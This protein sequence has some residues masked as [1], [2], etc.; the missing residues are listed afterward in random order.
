VRFFRRQASGHGVFDDDV[1]LHGQYQYSGA[2]APLSARL[3][4]ARQSEILLQAVGEGHR[5]ILDVGC[6]DGYFTSVL[7]PAAQEVVGIDPS[8]SAIRAARDQPDRPTNVLFSFETL[9]DYAKSDR[10]FDV[11][12]LRGVIHHAQ[13]PTA[14][15]RDISLI[16]DRVI[17]L[18]P[19]GL[20]PALKAV[21]RLSA[22]HRAH[23]ERSFTPRRLR[24][25][26]ADAGFRVDWEGIGVVV[27]YFAPDVL[28]R[29]LSRAEPLVEATPGLRQ[30][31]CGTRV[32]S[33]RT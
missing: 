24:R 25:W 2:S 4:T 12:V 18:E 14:L 13:D 15:L 28:A 16:T 7:S 26:M 9:H 29:F 19:N 8:H 30:V 3:A 17:I 32:I 11:V 33:A 27:P 10:R 1:A 31:L 22:Y 6:G 21:E 5:T 20:N 23:E